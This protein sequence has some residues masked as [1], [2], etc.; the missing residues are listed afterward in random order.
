MKKMNEIKEIIIQV[1]PGLKGTTLKNKI[2]RT[3]C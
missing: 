2:I 3:F 1:V